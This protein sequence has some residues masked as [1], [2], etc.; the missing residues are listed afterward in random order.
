M[1]KFK[2]SLVEAASRPLC[3]HSPRWGLIRDGV[4]FYRTDVLLRRLPAPR[5]DDSTTP[6]IRKL[7]RVRSARPGCLRSRK[8][9][10]VYPDVLRS[11]FQCQDFH[12]TDQSVLCGC[13]VGGVRD[14]PEEATQAATSGGDGTVRSGQEVQE[15][16]PVG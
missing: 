16:E 9:D 4:A 8:V 2:T 10:G 7:L 14:A 5:L 1:G 3:W 15:V 12:E 11:E 6:K 13:I